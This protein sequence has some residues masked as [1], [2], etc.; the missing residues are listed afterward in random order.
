MKKS[1]SLILSLVLVLSLLAPIA[2]HANGESNLDKLYNRIYNSRYADLFRSNQLISV[3]NLFQVRD[4]L[5]GKGYLSD[6]INDMYEVINENDALKLFLYNK[7]NVNREN[8]NEL[9]DIV[10]AWEETYKDDLKAIAESFK[11]ESSNVPEE[12]NAVITALKNDIY[13]AFPEEKENLINA[14]KEP[15]AH[16]AFELALDVHKVL[17]DNLIVKEKNAAKDLE[18]SFD[19]EKVYEA[20]A[21]I[22]NEYINEAYRLPEDIDLDDTLDDTIAVIHEYYSAVK[23]DLQKELSDIGIEISNDFI[24]KVVKTLVKESNYHPYKEPDTP[25]PKPTPGDGGRPVTPPSKPELPEPTVPEDENEA[26]SLTLGEDHI[27]VKTKDGVANISLDS[28]VGVN[29][30]ESLRENAG[31]DREAVLNLNLNHVK[32]GDINLEL[33]DEIIKALETNKVSLNIVLNDMEILVP[34]DALANVEI[35]KG[36]K[37]VLKKEDVT[38]LV[39]DSVEDYQDVKK[40]IDLTLEIII[41]NDVTQVKEFKSPITVTVEVKGL[42]NRDRLAAYYLNE[43]DNTLEFITGKIKDNKLV[44]KLNHFSKYLMIESTKTFTDITNHWG[45]LYIESMAAKNVVGGYSDGSFRPN[46]NVT[47]AEFSKMILEGL[48]VELVEYKGEF[49]DVKANDWHAGYL[50]TMKKLGLAEGYGDGT[51]RPDQYIT[52]AEIAVIL[53]NVI[54]VEVAEDEIDTLLDQFTDKANIPA[55]AKEA[56][57]KVVKAKVMVGS[58]NKFSPSNNTTRAESATTIYRIYNR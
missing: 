11:A 40:A 21:A 22:E 20:V 8:V 17:L 26:A 49:K 16:K 45:K 10:L 56:I 42:W 57:A 2:A 27:N 35:G 43:E 3:D 44:M 7:Y 15:T 33:S 46:N 34:F 48:E 12:W 6:F 4:Y 24:A 36:A 39:Q 23:D 55:W 32:T 28:K 1:I 19:K 47:R 54:D 9:K 13:E 37:V 29:A 30:V 53:S 31:D 58:N 38:K 41:G 14:L 25:T 50:A 52:R 18:F 51:Y 5:K